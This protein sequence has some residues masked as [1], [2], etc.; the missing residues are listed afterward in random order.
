MDRSTPINP[1]APEDMMPTDPTTP[2]ATGMPSSE[3]ITSSEQEPGAG[4]VVQRHAQATVGEARQQA[5]QVVRSAKEHAQVVISSTTDELRVQGREQTERMSSSLMGASEELRRMANATEGDS[6]I[7]TIVQSLADAAQ[8]AA[9]RLDQGGPE[10]MLDDLRRM[11]REHPARFLAMAAAG[12]FMA[13][14]LLRSTDTESVKQ[15]V[16]GGERSGGEISGQGAPTSGL[17]MGMTAGMSPAPAP[18][19]SGVSGSLPDEDPSGHGPR[20]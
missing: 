2:V 1:A 5:D 20:V 7:G 19:V 15:A 10:G 16:S 18:P 8:R 14:R 3:H 4:D 11:G 12:G 9:R 6:T 17:S 13:A